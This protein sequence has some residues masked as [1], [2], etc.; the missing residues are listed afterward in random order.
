MKGDFSRSTFNPGRHYSGVRMQQGRVQLDADWNENLD[1]LR[2]RIETETIDVIGQCGVPVHDAA[3]G[4]VT[5]FSSLA[6]A[7]PADILAIELAWLSA[8]KQDSLA[9]G[10]F[11]LTPGRA[12]VDGLLV[13]V[14]HTVPFSQQ[15]F[16][17][18]KGTLP[19]TGPGTFL[20][21][22][23]VWERHITAL[24][25]PDI[26][27]V[28]LGGPDT[29]TR[30]Q[31]IWQA[32][33]A[34]VADGTVCSD[35]PAPWPAASTGTLSA[36]TTPVQKPDDPCAVPLGAGYKR[37][38]NQL[39]RIEIH[40]GSTET[41]GPTFKW[42]RDN[43]SVVVAVAEFPYASAYN[44]ARVTSLG[45]DDV[46]GL[47]ENDWVE[48][49]DDEKE[50]SGQHGDLVQISTIDPNNVITFFQTLPNTYMVKDADGN[51]TH[52]KLRRW[53]SSGDVAIP[54]A[55]YI[56]IEDGLEV[57]FDPAGTYRTGDYWQIPARTVPGQY[58]DIEWPKDDQ[59]D[60]QAL[61]AF[62]ITHH[63]CRL[64]I[65]TV[66][67]SGSSL[68]ISVEDCRQKFPP[69]TELPSG[70]DNCCSV[71]VGQGGDYPDLQSALDARPA[72]ATWW[73]VCVLPGSLN[74]T[75][76]VTLDGA[77][78]LTISGCGSQCQLIAPQGKAAFN[79]TNGSSL[80]LE[81]LWIQATAPDGAL[82]FTGC[83]GVEVVN[84]TLLNTDPKILVSPGDTAILPASG[85]TIVVDEGTDTT[86]CDSDLVGLP[87]VRA[88]GQRLVV[89]DNRLMAG[90]I[91]VQA[92]SS[93]V[94]IEDNRILRG[95]G[96]GI[97][98]GGGGKTVDSFM[99]MYYRKSTDT[100]EVQFTGKNPGDYNK[101]TPDAPAPQASNF[102]AAIREVSISRNLIGW[103]G[104]S[105][106][107]TET[108]FTDPSA[109][110]DVERLRIMEN[111]IVGCCSSGADVLLSE[112]GSVGGG[113]AA[114]GLFDTQIV[115]NFIAESGQGTQAACGIFVLDGSDIE[116]SGNVIVENG[117]PGDPSSGATTAPGAYQ[118]GI[119]AYHIFGN[120]LT[121]VADTSAGL[122]G[123][124]ALR[125]HG[126]QVICPAGQA[127]TVLTT[128]SVVVDG[129]TLATRERMT[130][131]ADPLDFGEK[132]A[133]VSIVDMGVPAWMPELSFWL[134]A[135]ASGGQT[136]IHVEDIL[137]ADQA[138]AL[139]PDG[140][141]LFH[142]N[143]VTFETDRTDP[144]ESVGTDAQWPQRVW[145][146]MF[147]STSLFSLDEISLTGN[148]FQ[149]SVPPYAQG[150]L[151]TSA[152]KGQDAGM[153]FAMLFK[154][155]HVA[156][157]GTTV[158]ASAN[159]ISERLFSN[160]FSYL[161]TANILNLTIGNEMT[162]TW[163]TSALKD[164]EA[165]NLSLTS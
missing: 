64:A 23:D 127:L 79:F 151:Q 67:Q 8:Q 164:T 146:A 3:F 70:G 105:G 135:M 96:P 162:H 130:Q 1:I 73:T 42:S 142:N 123:Y 116:M 21:Y 137:A 102:S 58:G 118:A 65:L 37:L 36:R 9:N 108:D 68:T 10:D 39:Y 159:G 157:F 109:L 85:P 72:D 141:I 86:V 24:E 76:T 129:N 11:Y 57:S 75:D 80:R 82:L 106:I 49:L 160:W 98:L 13:E 126:N 7:L 125:I 32:V 103:M 122:L 51:P 144:L 99:Q 107:L 90:G 41:G 19:V 69:L 22:L 17:L 2:H 14:D 132:A 149:A 6:T 66:E 62:G 26:R 128:G 28:A 44:E 88:N 143:Q 110:G 89:R 97:Q 156:T 133:C 52:L 153:L 38:E 45:R 136:V 47:H 92:P 30:S 29:A 61:L 139:Y 16:V 115:G 111:E 117:L 154:F 46:L 112:T 74:L 33:T 35:K 150:I 50:L 87:A 134:Q 27:E 12:Y 147:F 121:T 77:D 140:R 95:S 161:S 78:T 55:S 31:I 20:L 71:T 56:P 124:P 93:Y 120:F 54:D 53:D 63:Y 131:P 100:M 5:D 15:P 43:G 113:I 59:G 40:K 84:C 119:A 158:R 155:I 165:D 81:G 25:D 138:M 148:G 101:Y 163:L 4:V 104:G 83:T 94:E 48:V 145:K 34:A 91:Q 114:L 152:Q 18:P 60:P